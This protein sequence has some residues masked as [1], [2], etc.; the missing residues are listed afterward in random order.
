[1]SWHWRWDFRLSW[2]G[3]HGCS[4][5]KRMAEEPVIL[6]PVWLVFPH[7][8]FL[9]TTTLA[10][11]PHN[12]TRNC[13]PRIASSKPPPRLPPPPRLLI[14]S[15]FHLPSLRH[16]PLHPPR[17]AKRPRRGHSTLM[18]HLPSQDSIRPKRK[19]PLPAPARHLGHDRPRREVHDVP[20]VGTGEDG[21]VEGGGSF[22]S[23][24]R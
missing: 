19:L 5:C 7:T 13:L 24:V 8:S 10:R 4:T 20:N 12:S 17:L 6:F 9:P 3:S 18:Q 14:L 16:R 22:A 21:A 11:P 2:A 1:M 15:G 23:C